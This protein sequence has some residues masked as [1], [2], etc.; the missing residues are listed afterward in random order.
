MTT[1][2]FKSASAEIFIPDGLPPEQALARTTHLG[3]GAHH[4]DLEIMAIDG[5]LTCFQRDDH[6]FTGVIVTDGGGSPRNGPYE[7]YS[8]ANMRAI[9]AKEQKK[10]AVVGEFAAAVLFGYPSAAIKNRTHK[11]PL[12]DIRRVIE[13][14]QPDFVYTHSLADKHPTHV[15]VALRV[16]EAIRGLPE[17]QRPQRLYGCEVWR[18]LGWVVD[19][20]KVVFDCSAHDNLQMALLGL[21]DSQVVGGKRYDLATMGRRRA[22]AT[23]FA[24]H[25]VDTASG[26]SFGI[27]LTPLITDPSRDVGMYVQS[28][29]DRFSQDVSRLLAEVQ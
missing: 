6:W 23:Y 1:D 7:N 18:D 24:S 12:D 15:A 17:A 19:E 8:D 14:T 3:I 26:L 21:F 22:H 4:D 25:G 20:D 28:Y 2:M 11:D 29:I 27:D 13:L 16:I 5:I 9:R 10:S